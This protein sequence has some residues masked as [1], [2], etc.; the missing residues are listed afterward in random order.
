[1]QRAIRDLTRA[2]LEDDYE[3]AH[4]EWEASGEAGIWAA[5]SGDGLVDEAR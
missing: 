3:A 1:M 4:A 5:V 2:G